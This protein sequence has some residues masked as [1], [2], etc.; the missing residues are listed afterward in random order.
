MYAALNRKLPRRTSD[1]C[2]RRNRS[3][4]WR[5]RSQ[6]PTLPGPTSWAATSR[7]TCARVRLRL[8][9]NRVRRETQS[10]W[11]DRREVGR[12]HQGEDETGEG[13]GKWEWKGK[14]T[15]SPPQLRRGETRP[16][17]G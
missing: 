4:K 16:R 11:E 7:R 8:R 17:S 9:W 5:R 15:S 2:E 1:L 3:G 13:K 10:R 6:C 12:S 14:Q